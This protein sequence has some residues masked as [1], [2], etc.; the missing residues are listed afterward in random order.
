MS[1]RRRSTT[2]RLV[3]AKAGEQ[4][5]ER[6]QEGARVI[7]CAWCR[8]STRFREVKKRPRLLFSREP[9]GSLP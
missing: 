9:K 6:T 7:A 2:A 5:F 8:V 4:L 3:Q 1:N